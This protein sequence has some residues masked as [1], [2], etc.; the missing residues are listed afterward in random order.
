[1][2]ELVGVHGVLERLLAEFVSAQM[3]SFAM[4]NCGG[5]VHMGREIVELCDSIVRLAG[6][7]FSSPLDVCRTLS[8]LSRN[9]DSARTKEQSV[10]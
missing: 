6:M 8:K 3:I 10:I 7:V 5:R 1:L 4:G 2:G 9:Y